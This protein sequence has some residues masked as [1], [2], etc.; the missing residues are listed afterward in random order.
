VGVGR[1]GSTVASIEQRIVL[2]KGSKQEKMPLLVSA[3]LGT[4]GRTILFCR[5]KATAHWVCKQLRKGAVDGTAEPVPAEEI[6][7]DRSQSQRESAL[8]GAR[9]PAEIYTRGCILD[10]THVRLKLFHACDQWHSSRVS[11]PLTGSHC[12]FR[13]NTEGPRLGKALLQCSAPRMLQLEGWT[14]MEWRMWSTL[15]WPLPVM[16]LIHMYTESAGLDEQAILV[17]QPA[18]MCPVMKRSKGAA[19]SRRAC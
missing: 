18:S 3:L 7:G 10:P 12:K 6:H 19:R 1:V 4:P 16:S 17:W 9:F 14:L 8:C 2:A 13:P 5:T 15:T 11:T